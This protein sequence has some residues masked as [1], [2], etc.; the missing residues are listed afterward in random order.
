MSLANETSTQCSWFTRSL[1]GGYKLT[2][3]GCVRKLFFTNWRSHQRKRSSWVNGTRFVLVYAKWKLKTQERNRL[4]WA[5]DDMPFS[6]GATLQDA[7]IPTEVAD[8][9]VKKMHC[10]EPIEW[11]YYAAGFNDTCVHCGAEVSPWSN[12]EL[13]YPQCQDCAEKPK[14]PNAKMF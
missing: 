7:V 5:L 2:N 11:L 8:V 9:Y 3:D 12:K 14:I 6:C 10:H 13:Y 4:Q 1:S